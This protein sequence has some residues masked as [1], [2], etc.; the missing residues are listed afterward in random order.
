MAMKRLCGLFVLVAITLTGARVASAA[1][2]VDQGSSSPVVWDEDEIAAVVAD[3]ILSTA[4]GDFRPSDALTWGD[5]AN[6]LAAWGHP[7][8]APLDWSRPVTVRELDARLV[9]ALGLQP[10]AQAIRS[11]ARNAGLKPIPSLGTETV[12]RLVGLRINHPAAQDNLELLPDQPATRAEAAYS[13]A[14]AFNVSDWQ[15][16][17]VLNAALAFTLPVLTTWERTVLTRALRLVGYPYVWTGTSDKGMQTLWDGTVVPGGFDCSGFVWRVY[18]LQ[19]FAGAPA[20]SG[21]LQGRTTYAMSGEVPASERLPIEALQPADVVFFGSNG[22]SSKPADIG[23]VGIYVGD[24]W[25]VHSSDH[26]VT[27]EPMTGWYQKRFAWAR[28]PL[29][30]AGLEA[31]PGVGP[32][33]APTT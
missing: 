26:G 23:H 21:V 24:G 25:F 13:L 3:G 12:A 5:L 18:K 20:L 8:A 30:E 16:Q 31:P 10:A 33:S 4:D 14:H 19:P 7:I 9:A 29:A 2:W 1:M 22:P 6:A 11:G 32:A 28:R 27:L 17:Q 15:K